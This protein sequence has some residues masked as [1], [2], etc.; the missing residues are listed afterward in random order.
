MLE[1]L[2]VK[3]MMQNKHLS[4]ALGDA[5]M[6]ELDR[7]IEYKCGWDSIE[8]KRVDR[9]YPSSKICSGCGAQKDMKLSDRVYICDECG[10]KIDRDLNAARN[11][12]AFD[13]PSNGRYLP[14]ELECNNALL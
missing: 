8:I 11:L 13:E 4:K 9:W 14:V 12:A 10:L 5:S 2:N 7:Q 6:S 3:G 1:D